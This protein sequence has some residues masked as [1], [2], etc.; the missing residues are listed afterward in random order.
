M[1]KFKINRDDLNFLLNGENENNNDDLNF[2]LDGENENKKNMKVMIIKSTSDAQTNKLIESSTIKKL[3]IVNFEK[4]KI[5]N[6]DLN[7]LLNGENKNKKNMK[8]ILSKYPANRNKEVN[9][10]NTI[11]EKLLKNNPME[12][13]VL[14][15]YEHTDDENYF[16]SFSKK[17]NINEKSYSLNLFKDEF[18]TKLHPILVIIKFE[19][20]LRTFGFYYYR[21]FEKLNSNNFFMK[22]DNE[23]IIPNKPQ[24]KRSE[25]RNFLKNIY[26]NKS[27]LKELFIDIEYKNSLK[28]IIKFELGLN[29]NKEFVLYTNDEEFMRDGNMMK[30]TDNEKFN[31]KINKGSYP[32]KTEYKIEICDFIELIDLSK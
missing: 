21:P 2:L 18:L 24:I 15:E 23:I 7:I 3:P 16:Y 20:D 12:Y 28:K 5:N 29:E 25:N 27:N 8:M 17:K 11:E 6:D 10:F 22:I 1:K 30:S 31:D 13:K 26:S 32:V 4:F 14:L 19:N 9:L